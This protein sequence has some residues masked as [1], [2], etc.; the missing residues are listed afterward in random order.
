MKPLG[1]WLL[2]LAMTLLPAAAAAARD[3]AD[4]LAEVQNQ[5]NFCEGTYALCIKAPCSGIPTL[6]RL[7]NYV[8]DHALCSCDVVQ[9][10]SM[11]P[12]ACTDRAPVSQRGRTYL[13]STYSNRFNDT[14][15]TLI[16][17][18]RDTIWAWCYGAP[19]VVDEN[20]PTKATCTC[21]V[22]KGPA[23]TL[24][25]GCRQDACSGIW[26][27]AQPAGDAFANQHFHDTMRRNGR[28]SNPPA[29]ACLLPR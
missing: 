14:H 13:I 27:A 15:R 16:C 6:D 9:G 3:A 1:H 28:P 24:G 21:P 12:G 25:G 23:S 22:E 17:S 8:I 18:S 2:A 26:S 4:T 7:G 10:W 29:A 20:D 19:C 11:G 5:A